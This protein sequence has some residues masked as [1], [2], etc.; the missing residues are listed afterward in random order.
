M[1]SYDAG[2]MLS[3]TAILAGI[4]G[5]AG[6]LT[7]IYWIIVQV[8][9][10]RIAR[11]TPRLED[12]L[13]LATPS[14]LV[15]VIV[16]AHNEERVIERLAESVLAQ[17]GIDF[18]VIVVLDRCTDGTL[19]KLR[20]VAGDDRRLRILEIDECPEDWAGKCHAAAKGVE[21]ASGDWLVFTDADVGFDPRVLKASAALVEDGDIDLLSAW[22]SLSA[23]HWWE[24]VVQPAA[25]IALLRIYPPD[26]VNNEDRPRS[27]ANGQFM[28]FR[29]STYHDI[30]G[31]A[32]VKGRLLEDLAFAERMHENQ[33]KV[34]IVDAGDMVRTN[35]YRSLGD[36]LMGWRR[37]LTDASKRNVPFLFRNMILVLGS[38]LVPLVCWGGVLLGALMALRTPDATN[39]WP[40][41]AACG[42]G[43]LS[44]G[45][46]LVR[47][48]R[49]GRM[50]VVGVLGWPIGCVLVAA[51]LAGAIR[52][53][54]TGRPVK[55]GGREYV[56]RPGPR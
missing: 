19:E 2:P 13:G 18:E 45:I 6:V 4:S 55:W 28:V 8:R 37:I 17:T 25:A 46:A 26:R 21:I 3:T 1:G 5:V 30:G 11:F 49:N 9:M 12:G 42:F 39:W 43:I 14:G 35:M 41:V 54:L 34:R 22:T 44:Q 33:R 53:L 56:L 52:D 10:L 7:G 31:H 36:L 51:T 27:F 40:L 29:T 15:S 23:G 38:G 24:Y 50:P 16:P 32:A 20:A 47:I 48:F